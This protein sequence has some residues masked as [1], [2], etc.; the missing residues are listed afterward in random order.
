MDRVYLVRHTYYYG[1]TSNCS[2]NLFETL[3]EA[4]KALDIHLW[5]ATE[6]GT[7]CNPDE[8][9]NIALDIYE[10]HEPYTS[11]TPHLNF[12]DGGIRY[13]LGWEGLVKTGELSEEHTSS[14]RPW[15]DWSLVSFDPDPDAVEELL[16]VY[17]GRA[18]GLTDLNL[19][20]D[21]VRRILRCEP[22]W[23]T[24]NDHRVQR[25]AEFIQESGNMTGLGV[26]ADALDEAGCDN[27]WLPWHLRLPAG[28][29]EHGS[30]VVGHI[31]ACAD[32]SG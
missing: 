9:W 19:Y 10:V 8:H 1:M 30:W 17:E 20:E 4:Q 16:E 12:R 13:P 28:A 7:F 3:T 32:Q 31:I 6:C 24:A 15:I 21:R 22:E 29:H 5:Y 25:I 27:S 18:F 26:L 11:V 14:E 23:L 2:H